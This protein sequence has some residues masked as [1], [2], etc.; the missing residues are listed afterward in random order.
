MERADSESKCVWD[1]KETDLQWLPIL[2]ARMLPVTTGITPA[3]LWDNP[4]SSQMWST[5]DVETGAL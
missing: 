5:G 1:I 2:V 4:L 3:S